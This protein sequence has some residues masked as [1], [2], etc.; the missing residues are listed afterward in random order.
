MSQPECVAM[1]LASVLGQL[2]PADESEHLIWT[3][4]TPAGRK[5]LTTVN[6]ALG[7]ALRRHVVS[8]S[9]RGPGAVGVKLAVRGED[10]IRRSR[11]L[12]LDLDAVNVEQLQ[13]SAIIDTLESIGVY[14]YPTTGS[15]GRGCHLWVFV[16][17]AILADIATRALRALRSLL[18]DAAGLT[19]VE[20]FPSNATT[21]GNGILLPYRGACKDGFG[22]NP[23]LDPA[24]NFTAI[25]LRSAG[26]VIKRTEADALLHLA[27]SLD[28]DAANESKRPESALL[29]TS[30]DTIAA[31]EEEVARL[32]RHWVIGRRNLLAKGLTAYLVAGLGLEPHD[33]IDAVIRLHRQSGLVQDTIA[34]DEADL[35]G[36]AR[37]TCARY[38]Q[39]KPVAWHAF[40][41]QAGVAPPRAISQA[42][43]RVANAVQLR[44]LL[45]STPFTGRTAQRDFLMLAALVRLAE[46]FGRRHPQGIAVRVS[47]I[48]LALE[49]NLGDR[50]SRHAL[51]RLVARGLVQRA[52]YTNRWGGLAGILVIKLDA[53]TSLNGTQSSPIRVE[54]DTGQDWVQLLHH[55]AFRHGRLGLTSGRI[56]SALVRAGARQLPIQEVARSLARPPS[57][58]KAWL[59]RLEQHGVVTID[60]TRSKVELVP[61]FEERLD[62]AAMATGA[63]AVRSR[64]RARHELAR[65]EFAKQ[66]ALRRAAQEAHQLTR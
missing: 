13:G 54:Q 53:T 52:P 6:A 24:D 35:A 56:V 14:A 31:A 57:R 20:T 12:A 27:S 26:S 51:K 64:Q 44:T 10:G 2:V 16:D 29:D 40:Y 7:P 3:G 43:V 32:A 49:A 30:I 41:D 46:R 1:E 23:L 17:G 50:G 65:A 8:A 22:A 45:D 47:T 21:S 37:R 34:D 61:D 60:A 28:F 11:V 55:P 4:F 33:A 36:A 9:V 58:V 18:E 62:N 38:L 25:P 19:R 48:A 15:T 63:N 59:H 66:A 42:C 5:R 39:G